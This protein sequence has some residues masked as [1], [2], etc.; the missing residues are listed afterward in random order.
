M[1]NRAK[2]II[3]VAGALTAFGSIWVVLELTRGSAAHYVLRRGGP[4][5]EIVVTPGRPMMML[6]G[7]L[8]LITLIP[9]A[10][11]AVLLR[12]ASGAAARTVYLLLLIS[13]IALASCAAGYGYE[14][15]RSEIRLNGR[16]VAYRR[17]EDAASMPWDEVGGMVLHW[18]RRGQVLVLQG[19]RLA[20]H[21][22]LAAFSSPDQVLVIR[23]VQEMA[24]LVP[25]RR[26]SGDAWVWRKALPATVPTQ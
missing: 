13:G 18:K 2:A 14:A 12:S 1:S 26:T 11:C 22:D 21:I 8:V 19:D 23:S 7:F 6:Y 24:H 16:G 4:D 25:V 5:W 10:C 9:P 20:I 17:G 15:L 3:R